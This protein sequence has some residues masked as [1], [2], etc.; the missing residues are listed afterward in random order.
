MEYGIQALAGMGMAFAVITDIWQKKIAIYAIF[1]IT[2]LLLLMQLLSGRGDIWISALGSGSLF[3]MI[4]L[5]TKE[6]IGK[7]DAFLF[8]MTGAAMGLWKNIMIIYISFMVAF[9]VALYLIIIRKK[10]KETAF[11]FAPC[12]GIAYFVVL[13]IG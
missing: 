5:L 6:K 11:P 12:I 1:G 10:R 13:A 2:V 9:V 8:G 7:G 4:S 3:Y